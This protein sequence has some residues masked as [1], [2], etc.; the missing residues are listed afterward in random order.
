MP[1]PPPL[2]PLGRALQPRQMD[3]FLSL[4]DRG[5]S[6][7]AVAGGALSLFSSGGGDATYRDVRLLSRIFLQR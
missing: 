6:A 2:P 3:L 4:T 7:V 1:L 5:G